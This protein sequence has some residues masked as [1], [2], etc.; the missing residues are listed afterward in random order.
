MRSFT[1]ALM[2]EIVEKLV[3]GQADIPLAPYE[4]EAKK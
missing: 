2:M 3:I 1:H 4:H